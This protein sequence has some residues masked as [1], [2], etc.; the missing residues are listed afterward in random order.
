MHQLK[1][2]QQLTM[3][4]VANRGP[5]NHLH[6]MSPASKALAQHRRLALAEVL[7]DKTRDQLLVLDRPEGDLQTG[8]HRAHSSGWLAARYSVHIYL[9][10]PAISKK[11]HYEFARRQTGRLHRGA[12]EK[13]WTSRRSSSK[14]WRSSLL[15]KQY[16]ALARATTFPK[17][18]FRLFASFPSFYIAFSC[19]FTHPQICCREGY[20]KGV[21]FC[22][23]I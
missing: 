12:T 17:K 9:R 16:Q 10:V 3:A 14:R 23:K 13:V 7:P 19:T 18:S 11:L 22:I 8:Y 2:L 20:H 5:L 6:Q 15:D 4:P 21:L 1:V